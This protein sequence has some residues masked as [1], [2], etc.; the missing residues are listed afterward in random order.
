MRENEQARFRMD[1]AIALAIVGQRRPWIFRD[2]PHR[3][4]TKAEAAREALVGEVMA[5]AADY[6]VRKTREP[7]KAHSTP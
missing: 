5:V 3:D 2:L 1:L 7:L 6:A 4:R